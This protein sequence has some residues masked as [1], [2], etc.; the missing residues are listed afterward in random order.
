MLRALSRIHGPDWHLDLVGSGSGADQTQ[1]LELADRLGDR[2]TVHG[3]VAQSRLA[4]LMKKAHLFVLPSF[5]EGLPLVV[6]EALACGC[7]VVATRLPGVGEI[8]G[9]LHEDFIDLVETPRLVDVDKPVQAD[10]QRFEE[11]LRLA[12]H[13]QIQAAMHQ[14]QIDLS[15]IADR[16][17]RFTWRGV[18]RRVEAVYH[19]HAR[20]QS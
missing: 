19:A 13:R 20:V 4:E 14:A 15:G 2:V 10:E 16:M 18:F 8:L 7:R 1:C 9:D 3:M 6:L 5:F 12:L 11:N 17:A